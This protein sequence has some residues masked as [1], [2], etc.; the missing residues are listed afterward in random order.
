M[1]GVTYDGPSVDAWSCGVVLFVLLVGNTPWDEP[2]A[3]SPEYRLYK[4]GNREYLKYDP[5]SRLGPG[6][7]SMSTAEHADVGLICGLMCIDVENRM[8]LDQALQHE[9]VRR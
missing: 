9:W 4:V 7:R 3:Y 1:K 2:T 8:S 5:W 6:A